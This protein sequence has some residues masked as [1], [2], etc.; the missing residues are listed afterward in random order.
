[1]ENAR[2][3]LIQISGLQKSFVAPDGSKHRIVDVAEFSLY[4]GALLAVAGES[5]PGKTTFLNSASR[6]ATVFARKIS[7]TFSR[8]ST[9]CKATPV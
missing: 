9:C 1:M 3:L 4:T 6:S 2:Q 5:G 7:A 8:P